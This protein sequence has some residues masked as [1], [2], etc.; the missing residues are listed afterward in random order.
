MSAYAAPAHATSDA[1]DFRDAVPGVL[2]KLGGF[3]LGAAGFFVG[4]AGLQ[5]VA[6]FEP[7]WTVL[8]AAVALLMFGATA[9]LLAPYVVKG[10]SWAAILGVPTALAMAAVATAWLGWSTMMLLF[11]PLMVLGTLTAGA[12][13]LAMPF[14]VPGALRATRARNALYA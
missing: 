14:T 10:R 11:S 13:A 9:V 7:T 4:G 2:V 12:A 6:F 3:V 8:G 1:V 5:L